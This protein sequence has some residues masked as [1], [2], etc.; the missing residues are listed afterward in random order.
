M[1]FSGTEG[2]AFLDRHVFALTSNEIFSKSHH[3]KIITNNILNEILGISIIISGLL[4]AFSKEQNEDEFISRIRLESLVWAT[5]LNYGHVLFALIFFY[6][7][8][9]LTFMIINMF[10]ILLFFIIRF[11]WKIWKLQKTAINEE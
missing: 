9:F 5:F 7:F 10:T 4:V 3:P 2:P 6:D 8:S 1:V 11:N